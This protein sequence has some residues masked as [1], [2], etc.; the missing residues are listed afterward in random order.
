MTG[1]T[2]ILYGEDAAIT[3]PH[4]K[5]AVKFTAT[6][7]SFIRKGLSFIAIDTNNP[8]PYNP[9]VWPLACE[10]IYPPTK[11]SSASASHTASLKKR[12]VLT[13][14][15]ARLTFSVAVQHYRT[16]YNKRMEWEAGQHITLSFAEKL[17]MGYAHMCDNE[18]QSLNDDFVRTFT[19][20]NP[21]PRQQACLDSGEVEMEI[22]VRKHGPITGLLFSHPVS[23]V[24]PQLQIPVLGVSGEP[25]FRIPIDD[26]G[27]KS[28]FVAG[29]MGITPL[30]AQAPG[31]ILRGR[32]FEV[33]WSVRAEDLYFVV[34]SIKRIYGLGD[35]M[36]LFITRAEI[37]T[38][39]KQWEGGL[40]SKVQHLVRKTEVRRVSA[41]DLLVLGEKDKRRFYCCTGSS[42]K[43]TIISWLSSEP[44]EWEDFSY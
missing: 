20:S 10:L 32:D 2:S 37:M 25:R 19:I 15:I 11:K 3:L 44:S 31:L 38:T 30:L 8:S 28:I 36:S 40:F 39:D 16:G 1:K 23:H 34:D 18:P 22:T 13:Q 17:D 26:T 5:L 4:S 27:E 42:L 14:N 41:R 9:A 43:K 21:P 29:G 6:K 7:S 12:E 24:N 35:R 33:V